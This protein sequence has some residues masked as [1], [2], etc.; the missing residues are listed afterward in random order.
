MNYL[1]KY[2]KYKEK[3]LNLKITQSG[4]RYKASLNLDGGSAFTPG[5]GSA[6]AFM[7]SQSSTNLFQAPPLSGINIKD[8]IFSLYSDPGYSGIKTEDKYLL[9]QFRFINDQYCDVFG[10]FDGHGDN[11]SV[12]SRI[13]KF[14]H[15]NLINM[16]SYINTF[17]GQHQGITVDALSTY[18][19]EDFIPILFRE[20]NEDIANIQFSG[21]STCSLIFI[22]YWFNQRILITANIG[23]SPIYV[24]RKYSDTR[25]IIFSSINHDAN[26]EVERKRIIDQAK[27]EYIA[28]SSKN[29]FEIQQ[30]L[31]KIIQKKR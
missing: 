1:K 24:F 31:F 26:N 28:L 30:I 27:K 22:F 10:I 12:T 7:D 4:Q 21:G 9:S 5:G 17:I 25:R 18:I 13:K 20:I 14:L 11:G 3:Y 15:S 23:D 19:V 6:R 16:K 29:D 2:L 8:Y